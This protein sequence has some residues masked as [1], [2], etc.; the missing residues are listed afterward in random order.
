MPVLHD[1][2]CHGSDPS[3]P[4]HSVLP[5]WD[6]GAS[7]QQAH[8]CFYCQGQ[9]HWNSE[10]PLPHH[11][12]NV[13][14]CCIVPLTHSTFYSVCEQGGRTRDNH[15]QCPFWAKCKREN[16]D[17]LSHHLT[18]GIEGPTFRFPDPY[19]HLTDE[20]LA[21]YAATSSSEFA[22]PSSKEEEDHQSTSA[23]PSSS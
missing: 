23:E 11:K 6:A 3:A 15:P 18:P 12:C 13:A 10:C 16:S 1:D 2:E 9:G 8:Q 22:S 5:E 21:T 7:H 17:D 4:S 19:N 14:R 20:A